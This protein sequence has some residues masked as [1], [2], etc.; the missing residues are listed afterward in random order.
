[1][2]VYLL[3][4]QNAINWSGDYNGNIFIPIKD[5]NNNWVV[6]LQCSQNLLY[7]F[8]NDLKNCEIILYQPVQHDIKN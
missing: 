4:E 6:S 1:M 5:K 7:P 8:I 3:T 2:Y